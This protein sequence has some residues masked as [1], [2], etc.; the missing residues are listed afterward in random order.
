MLME[1]LERRGLFHAPTL[2]QELAR[3]VPFFAALAVGDLGEQG[4]FVGEV[5]A[6]A[7]R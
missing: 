7:S 3:T 2:R 4:V 1:L 6:Q 5:E